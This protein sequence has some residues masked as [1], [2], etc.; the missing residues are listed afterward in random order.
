MKL[1]LPPENELLRLAHKLD[2]RA[3]AQIY[4]LYSPDIYRYAMRLLGD[5]CLAEECVA[6]TFSR[7]L[8]TLSA[9]K[10]PRDYL[11]AYLYRSAHNWIADQYRREKPTESLDESMP[12]NAI[13]PEETTLRSIQDTHLLN[14]IR[15][16]TPDQR[17]VIALKFWQDCDNEE[18]ARTL[19]KPVSAIKSLQHRALASLQRLLQDLD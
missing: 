5:E 18:I 10:G 4:D 16:L 13:A 2:S 14:A 15:R 17:Q 11:K 6:E 8:H 1:Q 3:L 19:N 9:G 7:F 12:S